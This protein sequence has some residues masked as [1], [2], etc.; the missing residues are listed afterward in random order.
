[1]LKRINSKNILLL[2]I[3]C[4][5]I[6]TRF[7]L[8]G[9]V[10]G[11]LNQDEASMGYDSYALLEYGIDRKGQK[12]PV[13]FVAWGSGQN[14]LLAYISQPFIAALG[15]NVFSIRLFPA[16]FSVFC[17][18]LF[19]FF[20]R[21]QNE[22][23]ALFAFFLLAICPWH[24]MLGRWALESNILPGFILLAT[25]LLIRAQQKESNNKFALVLPL[26][27]FAISLYSYSPAYAFVPIFIFC[28][29]LSSL[30]AKTFSFKQWLIGLLAFTLISFPI[31]LF[32]I[33]NKFG[34][35]TIELG[36]LT[37]PKLPAEPR[38]S[39][40]SI[41]S[42]SFLATIMENFK[43]VL[44]VIASGKDL[45]GNFISSVTQKGGVH[46]LYWLSLPLFCIG[47]PVFIYECIKEG[48]KSLKIPVIIWFFAATL[49]AIM[50][51]PAA[52]HRMNIIWFPILIFS[53]YGL[54]ALYKFY[55]PSSFILIVFYVI[56]FFRFGNIYLNEYQKDISNAFFIGY[57]DAI[58]YA[59][60]KALPADTLYLTD[61][62]NQP[63]IY[64][65]FALKY[66]VRDYVQT[67]KVS[68]PGAS[69]EFVTSFGK[70]KF[71]VTEQGLQNGRIFVLRNNEFG[72]LNEDEFAIKFFENFKVLIKN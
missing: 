30:L 59:E 45:D 49:T 1:M 39:M 34:Y 20:C 54:Y 11:G 67:V 62:L 51:T 22:Q 50:S 25:Y 27:I 42:E 41:F 24:I 52:I 47:F 6:F 31:I 55:K 48:K 28:Y 66:D 58:K 5:G 29:A 70:V 4:V 40:S 9:S 18:I 44:T 15:L 68:N 65:L 33:I 14:A 12:N 23:F 37:I 69:F 8:L 3:L 38:Y 36:V 53:G 2:L 32:V 72:H 21:K 46:P 63:Y 13:H 17:L 56:F 60:E 35:N 7:Y 71:G 16:L 26:S 57:V 19:Y 61:H 43:N 10:P 64:A